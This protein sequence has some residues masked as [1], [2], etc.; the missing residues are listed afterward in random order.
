MKNIILKNIILIVIFFILRRFIYET[1]YVP[2]TPDKY[3]NYTLVAVFLVAL[4]LLFA[5]I[6]STVKS[7][8]NE[9]IVSIIFIIPAALVTIYF[10]LGYFAFSGFT[11]F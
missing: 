6:R 5:N 3:V 9:R 10:I 7:R 2:W 11:G 1:Y 4:Y 8:G